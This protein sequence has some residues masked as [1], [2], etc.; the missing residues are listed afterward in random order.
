MITYGLVLPCCNISTTTLIFNQ[1]PALD[2]SFAYLTEPYLL[3]NFLLVKSALGLAMA[4]RKEMY[5]NKEIEYL[6][7]ED[8]NYV[9]E[10][11][12]RIGGKHLH[13]MRLGDGSYTT[14]SL[15]FQNYDSIQ[16]LTRDVVD[17]VPYFVDDSSE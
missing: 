8:E 12:V 13:T 1:L 3:R 9:G 11:H 17:K 16:E 10:V 14:H 2:V 7:P 15:P 5:R 4:E 6:I